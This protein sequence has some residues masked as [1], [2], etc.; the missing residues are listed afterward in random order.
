VTRLRSE[1][2]ES[3]YVMPNWGQ[4]IPVRRSSGCSAQVNDPAGELPSSKQGRLSA[5]ASDSENTVAVVRIREIRAGEA[6]LI[7]Q[8]EPCRP[9]WMVRG[10]T[11]RVDLPHA[12]VMSATRQAL[13]R[14]TK[15]RN[16]VG[17]GPR[18][19]HGE[20]RHAGNRGEKACRHVAPPSSAFA[21]DRMVRLQNTPSGL[22]TL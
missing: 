2:R 12:R 8:S 15:Y 3:N 4:F 16:R 18:R 1:R 7:V 5:R 11:I 17:F 20:R 22:A 13:L 9:P 19:E 21:A 14:Q 6:P 10:A